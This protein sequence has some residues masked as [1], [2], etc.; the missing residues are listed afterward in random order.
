MKGY[1]LKLSPL[2]VMALFMMTGCP[3]GHTSS[4]A[5]NIRTFSVGNLPF[6]IAADFSGDVWV[7]NFKDN[8]VTKLND[9]QGVIG[10]YPVDPSSSSLA[11]DA[12]G[13]VWVTSAQNNS[14]VKLNSSGQKIGDYSAGFD[15]LGIA[16]DVS[17]CDPT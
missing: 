16:I 2:F 7:L 6:K 3:S 5:Q 1:L 8:T 14:V 17:G 9:I 13:D 10:T 11:I 12:Q 15:P 4:N